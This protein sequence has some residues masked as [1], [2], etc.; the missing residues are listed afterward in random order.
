ME[1]K[2][3]KHPVFNYIFK[4][5]CLCGHVF[6][7]MDTQIP[8]ACPGCGKLNPETRGLPPKMI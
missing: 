2:L 8:R 4:H 1:T 7:E 6:F 5:T 3:L